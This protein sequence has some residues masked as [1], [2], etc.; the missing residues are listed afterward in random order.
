MA[1]NKGLQFAGV[2][3]LA[4][5]NIA[6]LVIF[7]GICLG[8]V[9]TYVLRVVNKVRAPLILGGSDLPQRSWAAKLGYADACCHALLSLQHRVA[10]LKTI[11]GQ[12][13]CAFCDSEAQQLCRNLFLRIFIVDAACAAVA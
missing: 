2:D 8:W 13:A 7:V 11:D 5:G 10:H 12:A 3:E 4:A 9:S 1:L 6:Q